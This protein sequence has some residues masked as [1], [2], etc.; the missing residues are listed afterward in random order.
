MAE[1][2]WVIETVKAFSGGSNV[3]NCEA[4]KLAGK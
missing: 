1:G 3:S 2:L 4:S